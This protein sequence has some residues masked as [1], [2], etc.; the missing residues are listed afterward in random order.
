MYREKDG[1]MTEDKLRELAEDALSS[2]DEEEFDALAGKAVETIPPE[3]R[4]EEPVKEDA[5]AMA[6]AKEEKAD[7]TRQAV[8][9]VLYKKGYEEL[10]EAEQLEVTKRI[11]YTAEGKL[12]EINIVT[13]G[14]KQLKRD[15]KDAVKAGDFTAAAAHYGQLATINQALPELDP[16]P[17][18]PS[19]EEGKIPN[20]GDKEQKQLDDLT[21]KG[22]HVVTK[23]QTTMFRGSSEQCMEWVLQNSGTDVTTALKDGGYDI[24]EYTEP[25]EK[26]EVIKDDKADE[27]KEPAPGEEMTIPEKKA[28]P[29]C[30]K[31]NS[32]HWP[33]HKCGGAK[34]DDKK[35]DKK[36]KK[37]KKEKGKDKKDKKEGKEPN[38]MKDDEET[39]R[40]KLE[41]VEGKKK[42]PFA[43]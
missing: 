17:E 22:T 25:T 9:L 4:H 40:K 33:M 2:L 15:G 3:A 41:E 14:I 28:V 35:P 16:A 18:K 27:K 26:P 13:Q 42:S 43:K 31:C 30:T 12:E 7:G 39:Q 36:D 21:E 11:K 6:L 24:V 38:F 8:S 37:D 20:E 1:S 10:G 34:K 19:A 23:E 29:M 5:E 32:K